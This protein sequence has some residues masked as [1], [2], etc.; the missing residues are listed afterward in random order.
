[1][2]KLP[3]GKFE[4]MFDPRLLSDIQKA[5]KVTYKTVSGKRQ[6]RDFNTL[7]KYNPNQIIGKNGVAYGFE[8]YLDQQLAYISPPVW[9]SSTDVEPAVAQW[10]SYVRQL[11][12]FD[13]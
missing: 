2:I 12:K 5:S 1:M 11:P 13:K 7:I 6:K 4:G 10:V 9:A 8:L 3:I